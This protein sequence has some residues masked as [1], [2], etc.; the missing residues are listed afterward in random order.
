M[1]SKVLVRIARDV[2]GPISYPVLSKEGKTLTKW[3]Y[4]VVD[5]NTLDEETV[6]GL[7]AANNGY[8]TKGLVGLIDVLFLN[9]EDPDATGY[10]VFGISRESGKGWFAA[11]DAAEKASSAYQRY[12][13]SRK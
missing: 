10:I 13:E 4:E 7:T 1:S 6:S 9:P 11:G 5:Y 3:M 12:L 8:D 2:M